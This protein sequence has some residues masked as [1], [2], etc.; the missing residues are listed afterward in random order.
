MDYL[1]TYVGCIGCSLKFSLKVGVEESIVNTPRIMDQLFKS[2]IS[3]CVV[4]VFTVQAEE[5]CVHNRL[6]NAKFA[7]KFK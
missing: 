7:G 4:C 5:W 2:N 3:F 1:N 6:F